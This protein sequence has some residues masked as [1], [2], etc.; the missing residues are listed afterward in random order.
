MLSTPHCA[1]E[2]TIAFPVPILEDDKISD[3]SRMYK[4]FEEVR[5]YTCVSDTF[6]CDKCVTGGWRT[7]HD[8]GCDEYT[9]EVTC[10]AVSVVAFCSGQC[11]VFQRN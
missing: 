1:S 8:E 6:V 3:L 4:L 2:F 11:E 7:Q 9:C 5:R 10:C